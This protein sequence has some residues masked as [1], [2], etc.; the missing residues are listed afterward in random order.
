LLSVAVVV[1][2]PVAVVLVVTVRPS[3]VKTLVVV[4]PQ[5]LH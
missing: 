2:P 3:L 5:K 4:H 1:A